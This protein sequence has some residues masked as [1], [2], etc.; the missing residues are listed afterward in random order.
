M[1]NKDAQFVV[2]QFSAVPQGILDIIQT[3]VHTAHPMGVLVN[4]MSA[5]SVF[6]PDA[7][8]ILAKHDLYQSK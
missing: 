2:S 3:M 5:L 4:V 7:H 8:S 1:D 6:H